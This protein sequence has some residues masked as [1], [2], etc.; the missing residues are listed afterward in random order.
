MKNKYLQK[1]DN[2]SF[3]LKDCKRKTTK[4]IFLALFLRD[5]IKSAY[6]IERNN[7][8]LA[9]EFKRLEKAGIIYKIEES[10]KKKGYYRLNQKVFNKNI[11]DLQRFWRQKTHEVL[12]S[13]DVALLKQHTKQLIPKH[14]VIN[15]IANS[16][17]NDLLPI[18]TILDLF[19]M[20]EKLSQKKKRLRL[21]R[22]RLSAKDTDLWLDVQ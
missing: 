9:Q 15:V 3:T 7:R 14:D 5:D 20:E 16:T 18:S 10:K 11:C 13:Y 19:K 12:P 17:M 6:D 4:T 8:P 1:G 22:K 21:S 2:I